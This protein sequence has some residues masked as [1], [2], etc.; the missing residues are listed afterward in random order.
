MSGL[1]TETES[2]GWQTPFPYALVQPV[3]ATI[4]FKYTSRQ[5]LGVF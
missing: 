4:V 5:M 1:L 2:I 3:Q